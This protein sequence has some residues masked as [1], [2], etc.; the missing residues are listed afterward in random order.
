MGFR[1]SGF[2]G[3]GLRVVWVIVERGAES[4]RTLE[5][6]VSAHQ[7]ACAMEFVK[8]QEAMK[9]AEKD[10]TQMVS[11]KSCIVRGW[12]TRSRKCLAVVQARLHS[13]ICPSQWASSWFPICDF[14]GYG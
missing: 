10:R 7:R 12:G 9:A 3:L 14:T 4:L 11:S 2:H 6:Y 13:R 1:V 8:L 5:D